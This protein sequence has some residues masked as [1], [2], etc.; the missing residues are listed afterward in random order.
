[1][2]ATARETEAAPRDGSESPDRVDRGQSSSLP[3]PSHTTHRLRLPF[4]LAL[5][6]GVIVGGIWALSEFLGE[7]EDPTASSEDAQVPDAVD[8]RL[9]MAW[10]SMAME[11]T[12]PEINEDPETL[13]KALEDLNTTTKELQAELD[14]APQPTPL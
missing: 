8:P 13:A 5:I 7:D 12:Q 2:D 6:L 10:A 11:K 4:T 14:H 1:M 9:Q 3:S